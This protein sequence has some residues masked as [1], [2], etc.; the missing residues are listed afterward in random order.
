[1]ALEVLGRICFSLLSQS[2]KD[3]L[4]ILLTRL[5]PMIKVQ[6]NNKKSIQGLLRDMRPT[7]NKVNEANPNIITFATSGVF[8]DSESVA[9]SSWLDVSRSEMFC[10]FSEKIDVYLKFSFA[11]VAEITHKLPLVLEVLL[12]LICS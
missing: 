2:R 3:R 11:Q 4:H 12:F 8:I 10:F 9:E 5:S 7:L 1:M 6:L